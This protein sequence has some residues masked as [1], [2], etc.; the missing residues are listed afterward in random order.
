[1][2]FGENRRHKMRIKKN[3]D[4]KNT[5]STKF[6]HDNLNGCA[7]LTLSKKLYLDS[8]NKYTVCFDKGFEKNN[9]LTI[10]KYGDYCTIKKTG[11]YKFEMMGSITSDISS[12]IKIFYERTPSTQEINNLY[13]YTIS[14]NEPP[15]SIIQLNNTSTLLELSKG[16][17]IRVRFL[18]SKNNNITVYS[19]TRLMIEK[20]C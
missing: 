13:Q 14:F 8:S 16:Q 3:H 4:N 5:K 9:C 20:I 15:N 18:S 2:N 17:K 7:F 6:E 10:S 1:M 11:V 19:G 12:N